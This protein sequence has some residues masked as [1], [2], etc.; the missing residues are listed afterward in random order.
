M[1]SVNESVEK[2]VFKTTSSKV[3]FDCS[4]LSG[5]FQARSEISSHR[6]KTVARSITHQATFAIFLASNSPPYRCI[7]LRLCKLQINLHCPLTFSRPLRVNR[8][9]PI[10]C[11]WPK[12]GS[13]VPSLIKA[14]DATGRLLVFTSQTFG[15]KWAG[16]AISDMAF[17][18][19]SR[20][21][22]DP[23]SVTAEPHGF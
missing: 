20:M 15:R 22:V 1:F 19:V 6:F 3:H 5:Y 17:K 10:S 23:H 2:P 11:I 18:D 14:V 12:G 7:F 16:T 13:A 4:L 8:V 9:N 21:I